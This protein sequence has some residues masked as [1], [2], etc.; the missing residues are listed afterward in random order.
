MVET[1]GEA[2]TG[3][4][5]RA[6]SSNDLLCFKKELKRSCGIS[7]EKQAGYVGYV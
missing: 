4:R 6:C 5:P 1:C 3:Y 2:R 7:G